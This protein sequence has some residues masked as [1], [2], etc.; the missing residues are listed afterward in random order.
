M[1]TS[2]LLASFLATE[3]AFAQSIRPYPPYQPVH[4][5]GEQTLLE[6]HPWDIRTGIYRQRKAEYKKS[7]FPFYIKEHIYNSP[8]YSQTHGLH[9]VHRRLVQGDYRQGYTWRYQ[10]RRYPAE[11]VQVGV[12][13]GAPELH[14]PVQ[15]CQNYSYERISYRG[16]PV[17][18]RCSQ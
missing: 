9:P 7:R 8:G 4:H 6:R 16:W 12:G 3:P 11:F 17:G 1:F 14:S 10:S 15:G 18:Y 13:G 2:L 5:H